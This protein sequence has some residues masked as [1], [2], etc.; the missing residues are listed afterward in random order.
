MCCQPPDVEEQNAYLED[1]VETLRATADALSQ[2]YAAERETV[3]RL[4]ALLEECREKL[5]DSRNSEGEL[6]DEVERLQG[7]VDALPTTVQKMREYEATIESLRAAEVDETKLTRVAL[8]TE[9]GLEWER[10]N[11]SVALSVQDDGRTLKVFVDKQPGCTCNGHSMYET[12]DC[13]SRDTP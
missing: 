7:I 2:A 8:I 11:V 3:E 6:S 10:Y 4:L 1:V 13:C 12:C 9:R 5:N